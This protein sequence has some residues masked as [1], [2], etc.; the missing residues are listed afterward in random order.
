MM[1]CSVKRSECL[2]WAL[3]GKLGLAMLIWVASIEGIFT[4]TKVDS[5]EMIDR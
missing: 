5:N 4:I 2:A 1:I 3:E